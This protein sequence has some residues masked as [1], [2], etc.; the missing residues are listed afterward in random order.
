M[1][2]TSSKLEKSLGSNFPDGER[3]FGFEN[4]GNTCYCNS[5]LQALYYC[6]PF[7][8]QL[9]QYHAPASTHTEDGE[10]LLSCLADLF[11]NIATQKK[12]TGSIAPRRFVNKLKK[13]N[14]L[15]RSYMHQDAHEF[16]NYVLNECMEILNKENANTQGSRAQNGTNDTKPKRTWVQDIFEGTLTNE[17]RCLCCETVT[18]RDEPFIDLSVDIEQNS[19]I[20]SCLK[21]FS[22]TETLSK[23]DKF[24]CDQ[25]ACLQEAEKRMRIKK[26]P[27]ILALH[28]KRFKFVEQLQRHKKLAHR[29]VFPVELKLCNTSDDC[30]D[31]NREYR[32]F[33]V[34][35]HIGSGPMHGHYISLV[36][37]HNHWLL[38]DDDVTELVDEQTL[39]SCFGSSQEVGQST[40]CGY[41][42]FYESV[43]SNAS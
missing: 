31:P 17:T 23:Q 37:S 43:D 32:L 10:T 14:E 29:V 15:F 38:F 36:K 41:I 1:G 28:L 6:E 42:L 27:R 4:F 18:S 26:L 35:V 8:K 9:L 13:E 20:T 3:F 25:C 5:V 19:S 12:K 34:V 21:N 30:E 24:F 16:F 39:Q 22:S 11:H 33:A 2:L 40:E 7:R